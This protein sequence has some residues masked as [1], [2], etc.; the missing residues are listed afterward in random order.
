MS[1]TMTEQIVLTA[2]EARDVPHGEKGKFYERASERLGISTATLRRGIRSAAP[3]KERRRRSDSGRYALSRE[4]ALLISATILH[5]QTR[6]GKRIKT[7]KDAVRMLREKGA[8]LAARIDKDTGEILGDLS[9][10]AIARAMRGYHAHPDQI[11]APD[12]VTELRSNHPNHVWQVDA[13]VCRL[14]YLEDGL[15]AIKRDAHYKN[16]PKNLERADRFKVTR[17]VVTDHYS[18]WVYARYVRGA[19]SGENLCAVLIDAMQNRGDRDILRGVPEILMMDKGSANTAGMTK[20]LCQALDIRVF[21][22]EKGNPRANGQVENGNNLVETTFESDLRFY[23]VRDLSHL[24][25]LARMWRIRF[26]A[27]RLHSRHGRTRSMAWLDIRQEELTNAPSAAACRNLATSTTV[28]RIVSSV[29]RVRLGGREYD[30]SQVPGVLVKGPLD[31]AYDAWGDE[32]IKV[33]RTGKDGRPVHYMAPLAKRGAGGF[34]EGAALI[35]E[36][37]KRKKDTPAQTARAEIEEMITGERTKRGAEKARK[38]KRL[39]FGGT[40]DPF[41][42]MSEKDARPYQVPTGRDHPAIAPTVESP[43]LTPT[44]LAM[45]L[46]D[47]LGRDWPEDGYQRIVARYPDGAPEESIPEVMAA[48]T[49]KKATPDLRVVKA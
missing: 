34:F 46:R 15:Q 22:H 29:L 24:N 12:P 41:R 4:E 27:E 28:K 25:K 37:Y 7:L 11:L 47:R 44:R 2:R 9:D 3:S 33:V 8:I 17:Y 10:G 39:P 13:S 5:A 40:I 31:V 36:E 18:G 30:V 21:P 35:G 14:W 45:L 43:R 1:P 26:N 42:G 20:N 19:E 16:K 23:T 38:E 49:G 32:H 6:D 48:V